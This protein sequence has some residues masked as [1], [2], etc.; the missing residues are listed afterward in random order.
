M[1]HLRLVPP[2]AETADAPEQRSPYDAENV[3]L[4][5]FQSASGL[6]LCRKCSRSRHPAFAAR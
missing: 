5:F 3:A 2:L 1:S 6:C 4:A